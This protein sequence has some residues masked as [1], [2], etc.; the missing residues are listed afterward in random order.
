MVAAGA[1]ASEEGERSQRLFGFLTTTS[2]TRIASTT[3]TAVT[4]C[5]SISATPCLGRRKRALFA[6]ILRDAAIQNANPSSSLESSK[7]EEFRVEGAF[8]PQEEAEVTWEEGGAD[9]END[10]DGENGNSNGGNSKKG[11]ALTIWTSL[12][13][14]I[15][16]TSTVAQAGT[17]ITASALCSAPGAVAGCFLVYRNL[18]PM[19]KRLH[20]STLNYRDT[21]FTLYWGVCLSLFEARQT[22][23]CV[24][25][26]LAD[27]ISHSCIKDVDTETSTH[28]DFTP[29]MSIL[30]SL[31]QVLI[32]FNVS[33]D[34]SEAVVGD[35]LSPAPSEAAMKTSVALLLLALAAVM[36]TEGGEGGGGEKIVSPLKAED[37]LGSAKREERIFAFLTTTSVKRLA[38]TTITAI[39]TCLSTAV[40]AT[41]CVGRR[42]KSA[43]LSIDK[44]DDFLHQ[45]RQGQALDD[46]LL[47]GSLE[48]Q[49]EV[50]DGLKSDKRVHVDREGRKLT[51]WS[52][53]ISTLTLTSTS[54]LTG[55]TITA[56]AYCIAPGVT[57]GCFGK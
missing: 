5:L 43:F 39:S 36:A 57:Q 21:F 30:L 12:F 26:K 48:D 53:Y 38:T 8:N 9:G 37:T 3:I 27:V 19:F 52:T 35:S 13:T 31:F 14:T 45:E 34:A 40:G 16:I 25:C 2:V 4:T 56:T 29:Y 1:A 49:L 17:T 33:S 51:I 42:K 46:T 20:F 32:K 24:V 18:F 22:L 50:K 54:Y 47:T 15:T 10:D 28:C 23:S 7:A 6:N 41:S 55:T 44:L 11:R